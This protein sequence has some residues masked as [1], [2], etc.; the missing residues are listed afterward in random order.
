[1]KIIDITPETENQ[2]ICCLEEWSDDMKEAG[3]RKQLWY[4]QMKHKGLKVKF[5]IDD[6][7]IIGGMIH[8]IPVEYSMYEGKNL[9]VVLCIWVHGHKQG[10]GDYR[11]RGMGKA[12]L[13]AAEDDVKAMGSG[14]LATWGLIIPVF[15]RASW[16]RKHG[17]KTVDRSG[18]MRLLWK[19]FNGTAIPPKFKVPK[20]KPVKGDGKVNITIFCNGWCQTMN[21]AC[22]RAKRASM[23]FPGKTDVQI[24]YTTDNEINNEWGFTDAIFI[25]GKEMNVGPPPPYLKIRKKIEKRVKKIL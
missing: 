8:Y 25:D 16:F 23:E 6:D 1:M 4:D 7:G 2:Y 3:N 20:K 12:L 10:R 9:H 24:Y 21:I 19:P 11:K 18:I 13:Q 15:M 17:Y 14:G 5:A 22:E